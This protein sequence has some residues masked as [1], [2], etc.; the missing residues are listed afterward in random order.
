[1]IT[2][3]QRIENCLAGKALD[4]VPVALWRHFPVDDQDSLL[5]AK[6]TA[7][8][9]NTFDFDLIKITGASSF[10][11]RDWGMR[12]YWAG[13]A[14]GTRDSL[15]PAIHTPEDW[16]A[17]TPLN[18]KKGSL[19]EMLK[20]MRILR[21]EFPDTPILQTIF[22]PLSQAKN[23]AGKMNL[24]THL[25]TFPEA[26]EY[27]LQVITETTIAFINEAAKTG[28]DGI[29]YAVQH[30]NP[31]LMSMAEYHRFGKH[32]DLMFSDVMKKFWFNLGHL[33]GQPVWF[34]EMLDYQFD[35]L[36]WHDQTTKPSLSA[37]KKLF[38]GVV[39]GGISQWETLLYG[40]AADA[41][42]EAKAAIKETKG[43][44]FILGAGCVIPIT[45]P[46]GNI[47]AVRQAVETTR[48]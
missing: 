45:T 21:S 9:Q 39:C 3:K 35:I 22:S 14:E 29:Y 36:N 8:F 27:G 4:R 10:C 17:L 25:R 46:Y 19:G 31:S 47:M 15:Q 34:D 41:T 48:K 33:H 1:M 23:L 5:L 18:P 44:R 30:A 26:V 38:P 11:V 13:N 20:T 7:Q 24:A 43:E 28:I 2:H 32:F 42:K 16:Q 40:S 12:D 6:A 37:G